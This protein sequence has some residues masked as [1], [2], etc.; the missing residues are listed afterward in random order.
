MLGSK[1]TGPSV[2]KL[3][4]YYYYYFTFYYYYYVDMTKA[5]IPSGKIVH[6]AAGFPEHAEKVFV[7]LV[8]VVGQ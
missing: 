3:F 1:A 7:F 2:G 5:Q 8:V 6:S 4:Y